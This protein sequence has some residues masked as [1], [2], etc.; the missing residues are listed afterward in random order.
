MILKTA[1][2]T[3]LKEVS[4]KFFLYK[5]SRLSAD[6]RR[7]RFGFKALIGRFSDILFA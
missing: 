6:E 1:W 7:N 4:P 3:L 2:E 5:I